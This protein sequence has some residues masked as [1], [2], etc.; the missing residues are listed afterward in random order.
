MPSSSIAIPSKIYPSW[1][2]WFENISIWQPWSAR[3]KKPA[4][5]KKSLNLLKKTGETVF[6]V[7]VVSGLN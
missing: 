6:C 4:G 1:D 5:F 7:F 3:R 2:F